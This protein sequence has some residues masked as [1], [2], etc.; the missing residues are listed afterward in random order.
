[1]TDQGSEWK[2]EFEALFVHYLIDPRQTSASHPQANGLSERTVETCR[3]A[4][5]RIYTT[6]G[7]GKEWDR[8]L[9]YIVL[10]YNCSE[11][12]STKAN[13]Y[14]MMHSVDLT[15]PP[16][17]KPRFEASSILII[18]IWQ[19]RPFFR[20]ALRFGVILPLQEATC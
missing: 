11:Q 18:R 5:R 6:R 10:G 9:P 14:S 17:A 4:L 16:A 3:D 13:P 2:E 12:A 20:G 8:H 7:G 15:L 19:Q 1:M